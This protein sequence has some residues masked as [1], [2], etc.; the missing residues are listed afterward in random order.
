MLLQFS[1]TNKN[2]AID[3]G[4]IVRI[5]FTQSLLYG[6]TFPS[7]VEMVSFDRSLAYVVCACACV[8]LSVHVC[9][10]V[11]MNSRYTYTF[12]SPRCLK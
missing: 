8:C 4:Y 9:V 1:C 3:S 2:L 6:R 10:H 7:E 12:I 5:V 11:C